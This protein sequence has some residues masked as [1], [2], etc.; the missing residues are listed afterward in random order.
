MADLLTAAT[1]ERHD[2]TVLHYDGD[3]D[4][5]TAITGQ[6]TT[7]VVPAGSAD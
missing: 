2:A 7:W 1:A 6:P 5:I 3:F 4:M